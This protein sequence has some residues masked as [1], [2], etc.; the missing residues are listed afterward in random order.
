MS[1]YWGSY[2]YC[3]TCAR[4]W[5]R[6]YYKKKGGNNEKE[7]EH[8]REFRLKQNFNMILEEYEEMF[9]KQKGLCAICG[10]PE[11]YINK[12]AKQPIWLAVDHCHKTGIVRGL[13]CRNCNAMI[14]NAKDNT[15][16]LERGIA[17]LKK[18]ST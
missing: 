10:Q 2:L 16:T 8:Y 5:K 14:G 18:Y 7:R 12:N 3:K 9:Q 15:E 17:Y 13:L 6:E 11:T 4:S 1:E